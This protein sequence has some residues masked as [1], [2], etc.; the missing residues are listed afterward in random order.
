MKVYNL[1][2]KVMLPLSRLAQS[3]SKSAPVRRSIVRCVE[4]GLIIRSGQAYVA[5]SNGQY[6]VRL[7]VS[8]DRK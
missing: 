7:H 2:G 4:C 1:E 6:S 8:C 5:R 3:S